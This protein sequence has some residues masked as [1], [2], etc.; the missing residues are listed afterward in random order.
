M[1]STGSNSLSPNSSKPRPSLTPPIVIEFCNLD[2]LG[3]LPRS[4]HRPRSTRHRIAQAASS[5]PNHRYQPLDQ[6]RP[7]ALHLVPIRE[8][9]RRHIGSTQT[10]QRI[11]PDHSDLLDR[12]SPSIDPGARTMSRP[13]SAHRPTHIPLPT[14]EPVSPTGSPRPP[15]SPTSPRSSF[16][17]S[18]MRTRSRTVTQPSRQNPPGPNESS[19]R[20]P[21]TGPVSHPPSSATAPGVTRSVSTPITGGLSGIAAPTSAAA[22]PHL[23]SMPG[24]SKTHRIRLVPH[25]ETSRSL[26]FDPVI[27]EVLPIIVPPGVAPSA[28]AASITSVG[29]AVNGKPPAL[30]LKIGRFTDKSQLPQP[31]TAATASTFGAAGSGGTVAGPSGSGATNGNGNGNGSGFGGGIPGAAS[32]VITGGG[33]DICSPKV[34][35]KSKVVSRSHAEIWC[36]VGGKVR[37]SPRIDLYVRLTEG[38]AVLH[39]GHGEQFGNLS[40]PYP[41]LQPEYRVSSDGSQCEYLRRR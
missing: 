18:F 15:G 7:P 36:E 26:A 40:E 6:P 9:Y 25:L 10:P 21:S 3:P 14:R 22:P 11:R 4:A 12:L 8:T 23:S 16:L 37:P 41:A 30:L 33:G 17:P 35:F 5:T 39:T 31:N 38:L 28:A 34:A 24:D 32:L 19:S 29:P 1:P 27:R 2:D 13:S 20:E